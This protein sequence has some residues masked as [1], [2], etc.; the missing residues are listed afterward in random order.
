MAFQPSQVKGRRRAHK[1]AAM[2]WWALFWGFAGAAPAI[3][4]WVC[5]LR[6]PSEPYRDPN[7]DRVAVAFG[8]ANVLYAFLIRRYL[9]DMYRAIWMGIVMPFVCI[10]NVS[11]IIYAAPL[12][13]DAL[14]AS[15][16]PP[17][18]PFSRFGSSSPTR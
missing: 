14:D 17:L 6:Q 12:R 16:R 8:L 9:V 3:F 4:Y 1:A 15:S 13:E 2:F 10:Y 5:T 11:L 18:R 7:R